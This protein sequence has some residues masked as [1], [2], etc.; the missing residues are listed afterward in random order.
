MR[1]LVAGAGIGGLSAGIALAQRGVEVEIVEAK[2]ADMPVG[3]GLVLPANALRGLRELGILDRCMAAGVPFDRNRYCEPD[4][5]LIV[6]VPGLIGR[7]DG[8]PSLAVHRAE[9]HHALSGAAKQAGV[10]VCYGTTVAE[11]ASNGG[12][13]HVRLSNGRAATYDLVAGFDGINSA[14]RRQVTHPGAVRPHHTGFATWRVSVPR[15]PQVRCGTLFMGAGNKAGLNPLNDDQMYL[16]ATTREPAGTRPDP[17]LLHEALR[18]RLAGYG[19]PVAEVLAGLTGPQGIVFSP[20]EEVRLPVWHRGR[21]LVAGDAAHAT[22]P[23]LTQ[24]AAMAVEDAVVLA[25][26]LTG[27]GPVPAVPARFGRARQPRCAFVQDTSRRILLAETATGAGSAADRL[28]R[29][30]ELPA[31]TAAVDAVLSQPA[32]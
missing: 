5:R 1:V 27:P 2:P 23:Q 16:F 13:A 14:L 24:G 4:G 26:L 17:R 20:I 6:E 18:A 10:T 32:W 28:D 29:I 3:V 22:A 30:R 19:G 15:D 31:R 8:L 21:V 9:L 7:R 25:R 12:G 11:V